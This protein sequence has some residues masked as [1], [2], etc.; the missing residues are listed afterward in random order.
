MLYRGPADVDV[1]NFGGVRRA[2][3]RPIDGR[4]WQRRARYGGR[5]AGQ[6]DVVH[7]L[8]RRQAGEELHRL[9]P[10]SR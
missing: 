10:A 1:A 2:L 7:V 6:A 9:A 5:G 3:E 8:G 4:G